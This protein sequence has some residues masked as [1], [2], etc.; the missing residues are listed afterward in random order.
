M[1]SVSS[2]SWRDEADQF[3]LV[4]TWILRVLML[5][6]LP[7]VHSREESSRKLTEPP[8]CVLADSTVSRTTSDSSLEQLTSCG[9]V[10]TE[11]FPNSMGMFLHTRSLS[12][13]RLVQR[14]LHRSALFVAY[15]VLSCLRAVAF[16]ISVC[17]V[18]A[19]H[20]LQGDHLFLHSFY[21]TVPHRNHSS[22]T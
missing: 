9:S 8:P 1:R 18:K 12:W 5:L 11:R 22:T 6:S 7:S 3:S 19:R 13:R 15:H 17:R 20:L 21:C 14:R 4:I 2:R 10:I 16:I